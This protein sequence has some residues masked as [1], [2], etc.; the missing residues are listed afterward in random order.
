MLLGHCNWETKKGSETNWCRGLVIVCD[1]VGGGVVGD[2]GGAHSEKE[3]CSFKCLD[4]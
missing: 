4:R 2:G 3:G 1:G